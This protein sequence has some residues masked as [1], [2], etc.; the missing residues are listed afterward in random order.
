MNEFGTKE[1]ES[2]LSNIT[3]GQKLGIPAKK[4]SKLIIEANKTYGNDQFP[5]NIVDS[6]TDREDG[7]VLVSAKV[8][9]SLDQ[10][11]RAFRRAQ[12]TVARSKPRSDSA[13]AAMAAGGANRALLLLRSTEATSKAFL[14]KQSI[15]NLDKTKESIEKVFAPGNKE[16]LDPKYTEEDGKLL[17]KWI[18]E[19]KKALVK[20]GSAT[21]TGGEPSPRVV[22]K[23]ERERLAQMQNL[24]LPPLPL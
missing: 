9:A 17:L 22:S 7:L 1:S 4:A 8:W 16:K 11:E 5:I 2:M 12:E 6:P 24:P 18:A 10:V 19:H 21:S 3:L 13:K 20:Q 23:T 15:E 14:A